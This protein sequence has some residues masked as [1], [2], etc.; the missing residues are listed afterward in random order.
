MVQSLNQAVLFRCFEL[1]ATLP[2]ENML[3]VQIYDW[4]A[5]SMDDLIGETKIDLESRFYSRHRALCGLQEKY[6]RSDDL[7]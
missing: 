3:T 6:E 5:T 2:L 4:D 7:H 1:K